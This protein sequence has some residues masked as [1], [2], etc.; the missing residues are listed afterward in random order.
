MIYLKSLYFFIVLV[1]KSRIPKA[2]TRFFLPVGSSTCS[3]FVNNLLS[4]AFFT[5]GVLSSFFVR[6]SD[7]ISWFSEFGP[8]LSS[9]G[10]L[11]PAIVATFCHMFSG[12]FLSSPGVLYTAIVAIFYHMFGSK[13][14]SFWST[15]EPWG[16]GVNWVSSL[17]VCCRCW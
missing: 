14:I 8:F 4:C 13:S 7:T 1:P 9:L 15:F 10:V 2:S 5:T 3:I 17:I 6:D 12:P 11:Y 16:V